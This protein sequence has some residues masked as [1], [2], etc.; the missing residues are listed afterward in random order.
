MHAISKGLSLHNVASKTLNYYP[1]YLNYSSDYTWNLLNQRSTPSLNLKLRKL[2]IELLNN[3][4][5][6]HFH[7]GTTLTFDYSDLPLLKTAQKP[8]IMHHWGSDVRL[9]SV[10]LRTNP[11]ALV[12]DNNEEKII[13]KLKTLSGSIKHCIIPDYE[14][15]PFVKDFYEKVHIIPSMIDL[16]K[17]VPKRDQSKNKV[18]IIVHAPTSPFIKGTKYILEAVEKLKTRHEFQFK[19]VQGISHEEAK[20]IYKQADLIIDQLHIGSYG[21]FS[22]EAMALGKPVMCWITD[23]MKKYYSD[24]LP[25]ISANPDTIKDSL[26]YILKNLDMLSDVGKNSRIYVEKYHDASVNSL[27]IRDIYQNL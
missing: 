25:I 12:K 1:Y 11:Y 18:P 19:L 14:L 3:H 6:F 20:E 27:L 8:V 5:L 10:A 13:Q 21:L 7:F 9:H 23:E 17:Y 2:T 26:E 16:S 15:F 22:V 4:D 24:D